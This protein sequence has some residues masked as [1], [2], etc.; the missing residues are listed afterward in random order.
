MHSGAF[1][2][3]ILKRFWWHCRCDWF[4]TSYRLCQIHGQAV[5]AV[6]G[7][8]QY[9]PP[10]ANGELNSHPQWPGDLDLEVT[11]HVRDA[12]HRTSS[13]HRVWSSSFAFS[14]SALIGLVTLTFDLST[15]KRGHGS[16]V[17]WAS[18][19]SIFSL[20]C[21]SILDLAACI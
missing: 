21:H 16:P 10:P 18:L 3:I 8:S 14:V 17:S 19:L 6:M 15:S 2:C 11:A 5:W 7:P 12:G 20:L 1:F 4:G 13:S 9:A